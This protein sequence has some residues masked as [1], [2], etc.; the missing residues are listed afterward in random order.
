MNN[1]LKKIGLLVLVF[2]LCS[3]ALHKYYLSLTDIQYNAKNQSLE[4]ITN[5]FIDDIELEMNKVYQ[6]KLELD[7]PNQHKKTDSI[8]ADYFSN[9]LKIKVGGALKKANYL[10][11]E[12][13]ADLVYIYQE[14]TQIDNP[15]QFE[16]TNTILIQEFE[17]QQN[18]VKIKKGK[19]RRSDILTKKNVKSVLNF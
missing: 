3:F 8:F 9:K 2:C 10:G 4:I 14:I 6:V 12:I 18:V 7:T 19:T 1:A 15:K 5:V 17:D 11:I 13:D 16:I